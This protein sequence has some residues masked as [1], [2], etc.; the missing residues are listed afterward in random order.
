MLANI[1]IRLEQYAD[2]R[3]AQTYRRFFKNSQNDIFL[4]VKADLIR[5]VA[6]E[7]KEISLDHVLKLMKSN[8][9]EERSVA[10]AILR[11][12]FQKSTPENKAII[13]N[14]YI[15]NRENIRD[16]DGVDDSAPY[17][18]GPY[19]L[20]KDKTILYELAKSERLWDRR[21]A[22]VSTWWFIRNNQMDDTFKIAQMLLD[23]KEDL[24]HKATGWMLREAGKRNIEALKEFLDKHGKNMHRT[25]LRYA[26]EKF[27]EHERKLYLN[28][29]K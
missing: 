11:F 22:I 8:V 3:K 9:H 24:I 15:D 27:S 26:I 20:D 17:I 2:A 12:K 5:M 16:W 25:A 18:V 23:D 13:F 4:G 1:R 10:H 19:L 21:I 6:K 29:T 28:K 14:F 7:F